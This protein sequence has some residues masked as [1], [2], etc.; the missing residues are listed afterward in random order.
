MYLD[1]KR[2]SVVATFHGSQAP[3]LKEQN[4]D[5][6][7]KNLVETQTPLFRLEQAMVVKK[8]MGF[9]YN[10]FITIEDNGRKTTQFAC[11]FFYNYRNRGG[12]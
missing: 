12:V 6:I 9:G 5:R 8:K 10:Y 7:I 4:S 2:K 1:A 3:Y 11:L